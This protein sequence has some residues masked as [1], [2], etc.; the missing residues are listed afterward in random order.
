MKL[1]HGPSETYTWN[2]EE[3]LIKTS[4]LE[5]FPVTSTLRLLNVT[6]EEKEST[7]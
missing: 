7:C 3:D 6:E 4:L 5:Y 1:Q 2:Y